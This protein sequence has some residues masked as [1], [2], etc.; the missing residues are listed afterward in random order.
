M[1]RQAKIGVILLSMLLFVGLIWLPAQAQAPITDTT[2]IVQTGDSVSSIAAQYEV[3]VFDLITANQLTTPFVLYPGQQLTIPLAPPPTPEIASPSIQDVPVPTPTRRPISQTIT[4][5]PTISITPTSA[6]TP[7]TTTTETSSTD[8]IHT[9]RAGDTLFSIANQYSVPMSDIILAN[10]LSN[11]DLLYTG[12]PLLIPDGAPPLPTEL[13]PPFATIELS[14]PVIIQ[15]RTLVVRVTLSQPAT[16]QG[17]MDGRPLTFYGS[18]QSKWAI[19]GIHALAPTGGYPIRLTAT[20][21][22]GQTVTTYYRATVVDGPYGTE[23]IVLA[24]GRDSLLAP[25]IVQAEWQKISSIWSQVTFQKWWYGQFRYPVG[26]EAANLITSNFGTRR[27]YN[28]GPPAGF[29]GGTDFGGGA[30]QPIYAPAAGRVVLAEALQVRGNAVLIDHGLGLYSG[31]WHQS[32]IVV[33]AGQTVQPGDLIGYVG[34][35]GLV[36]GP[37]LHWEMRLHGYAVEPMQWLQQPIP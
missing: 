22:D 16:V 28:S 34:D 10:G 20:L 36:T 24:E 35:T 27:T 5:T 30:G 19:I 6:I 23:N 14:E 17:L 8:Q 13:P 25:E 37:H 12:Q 26:A 3:R 29:H 21:P 32:Q 15:G 18:Q 31:Y 7:L 33:T 2:H 1:K 9:V 4:I 11:P